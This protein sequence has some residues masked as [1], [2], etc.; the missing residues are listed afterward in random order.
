M[1]VLTELHS[2]QLEFKNVKTISQ[3]G[4]Y[5]NIV[6]T[7]REDLKSAVLHIT[8]LIYHYEYLFDMKIETD[9]FVLRL[10][11]DWRILIVE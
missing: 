2:K 5:L 6:F 7:N 1:R 8:D 9:I 3:S 10:S 11:K 4:G